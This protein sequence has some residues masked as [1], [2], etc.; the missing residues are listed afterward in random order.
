AQETRGNINGVVQDST[1]VVPGAVVRV[2]NT[3]TSQTQQLVTNS[4]GYFEALL[5]NAGTYAVRVEMQSFKTLNQTNISLAVGQ[6]LSL[7]LTLEVGQL[8][9]QV[10]VTAEAPILDTST[11]SSG[12]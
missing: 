10:N 4:K 5:L 1:G 12:M 6:T 3:D 7:T 9:E 8:S 11:V 2:T